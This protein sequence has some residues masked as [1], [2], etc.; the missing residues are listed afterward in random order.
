MDTLVAL[1]R[2]LF[3]GSA[4]AW[5]LYPLRAYWRLYDLYKRLD[6]Q[7]SKVGFFWF[8]FYVQSPW[9]GFRGQELLDR[10]PQDLRA[11]ASAIRNRQRREI[12]VIFLWIVILVLVGV[13]LTKLSH[14]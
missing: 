2:Y 6:E 7:T 9:F 1:H 11:Q 8:S 10:L 4:I 3:I 13:L 5:G 14:S 12:N